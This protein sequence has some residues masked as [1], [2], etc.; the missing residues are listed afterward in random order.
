MKKVYPKKEK[1]AFVS[2][3]ARNEAEYNTVKKV[4]VVSTRFND[5]ESKL[6]YALSQETGRTGTTEFLQTI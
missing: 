1:K 3:I 5:F 4:D 2:I 6:N